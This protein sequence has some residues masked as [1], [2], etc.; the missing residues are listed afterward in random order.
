MEHDGLGDA[1]VVPYFGPFLMSSSSESIRLT[2]L[3]PAEL[4]KRTGGLHRTLANA[5]TGPFI[6]EHLQRILS[7]V[8]LPRE[9][10]VENY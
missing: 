1:I 8:T 4:H 5:L 7:I 10:P 3:R 9:L 2:A 6:D